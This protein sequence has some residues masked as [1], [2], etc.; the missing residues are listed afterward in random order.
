MSVKHALLALLSRQPSSTYQLRK[1][2]DES[3]GH[4]WPLNIGQVSTTMQRLERDGLVARDHADDSGPEPWCLTA[5]GR[6][7]LDLW[8]TSPVSRA[9]QG[10]DELVVKLALAVTTPGVDVPA[11][12]QRQ[13]VSTQQVLH[14]ITRLRSSSGADDLA[15]RLILDSHLFATEAELRW[16][17]DIEGTLTRAAAT[18]TLPARAPR[19]APASTV[20][21]ES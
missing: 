17:D 6:D 2:F 8:W 18:R 13:R 15:G 5:P 9:H 10:R 21:S 11:L 4:A 20:R 12:I 7:E 3:T 14:D 16:L 1:D 19:E